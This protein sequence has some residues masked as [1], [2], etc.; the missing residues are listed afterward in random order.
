MVQFA[1]VLRKPPHIV[2]QR[3]LTEFNVQVDRFR[4]PRRAN[5]FGSA[6]LVDETR[7]ENLGGLWN[8]L[9]NR[10]YATPT[11]CLSAPDYERICPGDAARLFQAAADAL[12][13]RVDVLGSG[14]ID[15]GQP[16]DW[17]RDFKTGK[18]WPLSFMR[19]INYTNLGCPSDVKVPWELSR[20]QW[21]MPA[22]QA[23]LLTRDEQYAEAARD[24]LDQWIAAN[25][26]AHGVNWTCTMEAA[27]RI[28]SWTWFFH[29]FARSRAWADEA[30][31]SRFLGALFLHGE[32]TARHLER[33]DINGNHFTADAAGLVFVGL[34][35]GRGEAPRRWAETGWRLLC[36]ELPRQVHADGVNFE[37]SIAY[38]RLVLE[39][40]FL[41]ARYREATGLSVPDDYR[42]RLIAMARFT[43]AYTR[44]DGSTPLV[45]DADDARALPF[46]GQAITD[47]RYLAA[48][49][50]AHWS[51]PDLRARCPGSRVEVLWTL[52][53][54]SAASL[55]EASSG[56]PAR[57]SSA[58]PD[59][60]FY[61]MQNERDHVF[62]DCGPVGQ[63]GRG[64]HGHNDCLSLEVMLDQVHLVAD[65]GAYLYTAN[66]RERNHFRSTTCH[67]TPQVDGEEINRFVRWDDL[68][69]L[70]NDAR[71]DVRRWDTSAERDIF[72]GAHSGYHRMSGGITPV[73]TI[74]LDH[75]TH[76][77]TIED[78]VE[79]E[80]EHLVTIP[81]HLAPGV[82]AK[83]TAAGEIVLSAKGKT[84]ALTWAGAGWRV[85]IET[86]R[87]SPRYGVVVPTTRVV[88]Q[89]R[90]P[91]P[92]V[93]QMS[94]VPR[95]EQ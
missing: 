17:H 2:V 6:A 67:N 54:S 28:L 81:V 31:R 39:L 20:L 41:A 44:S 66:A 25:P 64:G 27:M 34:F 16:I 22:G 9:S 57:T 78:V 42:H 61:V 95:Q 1:R 45:G 47:H 52:G 74:V 35:F 11:R 79:G 18:T 62:I 32:F 84:F 10:V 43:G 94:I 71:P 93:L 4:A 46:G 69:S 65:C 37:A 40:F 8:W 3:M 89:G 83:T 76:A 60:G 50:G 88:W 36:R 53:R 51:V 90:L 24:V 15:L 21:L 63:A 59:G 87:V 85:S 7:A 82:T 86:A 29:V 38:H 26:L 58:F 70:H 48:L 13:H 68:W 80:G 75:G 91:L 72:V 92:A 77:L 33:S 30:F 23:Y 49:I 5:G 12:A 73:R 14:P 55:P 56:Q 19:D